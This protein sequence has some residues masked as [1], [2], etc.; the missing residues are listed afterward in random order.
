MTKM[1]VPQARGDNLSVDELIKLY[2]GVIEQIDQ[3]MVGISVSPYI[4]QPYCPAGLE[5]VVSFTE[6]ND[7]EMPEDLTILEGDALAK[8]FSFMSNW[9]SYVQSVV[10]RAK[11]EALV[12]KRKL[13]VIESA[14]RIYL[15]E[16]EGLPAN[17][18]GDAMEGHP[19]WS[20]ADLSYLKSQ[21]RVQK[22][23][24]RYDEYRRALHLISREQTRRGEDFR[25]TNHKGPDK[26]SRG[27]RWKR[28]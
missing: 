17:Q 18:V 7:P 24:G 25:D 16:S 2:D 5:S 26:P 22:V 8:L 20:E 15:K 10:T 12:A 3:E 21:V 9:C 11:C 14:L 19:A 13:K 1:R 27:G 4:N 6:G 28:R 23:E